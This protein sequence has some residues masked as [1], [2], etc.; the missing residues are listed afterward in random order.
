MEL[1]PHEHLNEDG[2]IV[3]PGYE[4]SADG[5]LLFFMSASAMGYRKP[6]KIAD[7]QPARPH[8]TVRLFKALISQ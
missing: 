3:G 6:E 5:D 1:Q 4:I 8:W 2:N 7:E